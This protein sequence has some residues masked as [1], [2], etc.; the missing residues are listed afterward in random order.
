[1]SEK[2]SELDHGGSSLKVVHFMRRPR[3]GIFSVER[4]HADIRANLDDTIRVNIR[5][6]KY[7]SNGIFKRLADAVTAI[8]YQGDINHI[9]GDTNYLTFFLRRKT[10]ILTILDFVG[11]E[12]SR[13]AKFWL[14][15]FFWYWLPEKRSSQIVV[16]SEAMKKQVVRYL[17]CDP[18][19]I[20]VIHCNVSDEFEAQTKCF[21][22]HSPRI[23]HVGTSENKNLER[24]I[25]ALSQV[26]CTLVVIGE[27]SSAQLEALETSSLKYEN[28]SNLS[29]EDVVN[30]YRRSDLLL[31]SSLYEGF[32]LPI[33]EAQS[34]GR[35]VVTSNIWSMP[36]V[37]G[38]G[39]VYVD[40]YSVESIRSGVMKVITS[41]EYRKNLIRLGFE[42]SKRFTAK[43]IGAQYTK[44][45]H[46]VN[47]NAFNTD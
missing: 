3:S 18:K 8:R 35:P 5:R 2:G 13:G 9:T 4:L 43:D 10:T 23:L 47:Q 24:H 25:A 14:L 19:K 17:H 46:E 7:F 30:E 12:S 11:L 26:P 21:D 31:F 27:L 28:L 6:N 36:E 42:N 29:R 34:V 37:A 22:D 32:G 16:I 15:W 33:L 20:R 38:R 45:Y 44:L 41:P 40:P 1:M 39:A